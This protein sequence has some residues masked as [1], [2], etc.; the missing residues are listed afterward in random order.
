MHGLA[1]CVGYKV[2]AIC[3]GESSYTFVLLPMCWTS[4]D[5]RTPEF[6]LHHPGS[7]GNV[8]LVEVM[9]AFLADR[10]NHI[11]AA[12]NWFTSLAVVDYCTEKGMGY[13]GAMKHF[14]GSKAVMLWPVSE[15][16]SP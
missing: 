13:V 16:W 9:T 3:D 2:Y 4:R 5:E 10:K 8:N 7:G 11:V 12:D 6:V 15:C 14:R 1:R